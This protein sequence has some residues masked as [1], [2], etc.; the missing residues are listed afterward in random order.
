[1][2]FMNWS[3][4]LDVYLI[5]GALLFAIGIL[6]FLKHKTLIGMLISG[7]LILAGASLNFMAFG[8]FRAPNPVTGQAFTLFIIGI[9]AAETAIVLSIMIAVYRNYRSIETRELKEMEG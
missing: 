3:Q 4:T 8:Y 6:G 9:A 1:M 7:E 2:N 5:I